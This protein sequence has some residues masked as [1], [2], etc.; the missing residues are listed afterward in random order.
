MLNSLKSAG[1]NLANVAKM[2]AQQDKL[3]KMLS[4]VR[5]TGVS[6]NGKVKVTI[7]G[8]QKIV[9]ISIDPALVRFVYENFIS[10][11]KPD[12]MMSK[13]IMEAFEDAVS[14]VQNEVIQQLSQNGG[15]NDLME[16]LQSTSNMG[17]ANN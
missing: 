16:V 17:K 4:S 11:N 12:V 3:T 10:Q 6:K 13:A 9:D 7:T 14:K 8:D 2:K 5:V 15:I 1:G